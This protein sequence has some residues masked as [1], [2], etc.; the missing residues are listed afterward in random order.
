MAEITRSPEVQARKTQ[1]CAFSSCDREIK[2]GE[3]YIVK[4]DGEGWMHSQCAAEHQRL[5]EL[6]DE[7]NRED[8][9]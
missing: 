4:I 6:Y 2:G 1:P 8:D 9:E 7:L 3:D 5:R